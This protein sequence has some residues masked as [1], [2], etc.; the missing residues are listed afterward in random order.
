MGFGRFD[1]RVILGVH[2]DQLHRL[3]S[4]AG[5]RRAAAVFAPRVGE[6]ASRFVSVGANTA[7]RAFAAPCARRRCC[8]PAFGRRLSPAA[9]VADLRPRSRSGGFSGSDR[10]VGMPGD[11]GVF[12]VYSHRSAITHCGHFGTRAMQT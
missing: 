1:D 6:E 4:S 12:A 7:A 5:Q 9:F 8:R 11:A 10:N 3:R 2:R